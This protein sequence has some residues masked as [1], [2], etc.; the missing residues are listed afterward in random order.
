MSRGLKL[1]GAI[2]WEIHPFVGVGPICFGQSR[3]EVLSLLGSPS[4]TFKKVPFAVTETDAFNEIG[5]HV[6]YDSTFHV[7][8]IDALVSSGLC[9]ES[10]VLL[11]RPVEAVVSEMTFRGYTNESLTFNEIGISLYDVDGIVKCVTIFPKGYFDLSNPD[12][13]ASR[14]RAAAAA[15]RRKMR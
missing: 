7:E 11:N 4:R 12:S 1:A 2:D 15:W 6:Y 13:A 8:S 3:D 10:V 9:F 5:L 14:A